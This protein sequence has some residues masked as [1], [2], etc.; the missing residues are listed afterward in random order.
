MVEDAGEVDWGK[1]IFATTCEW[2]GLIAAGTFLQG[3][4]L[5]GRDGWSG[6][7]DEQSGLPSGWVTVVFADAGGTYGWA[8]AM[9]VWPQ[10]GPSA[11]GWPFRPARRQPSAFRA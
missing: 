6:R 11:F 3:L 10:S 7:F 8:P 2:D 5:A 1:A 4:S 9:A